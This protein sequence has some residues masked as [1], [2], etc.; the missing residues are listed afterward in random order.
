MFLSGQL[1][2]G[3]RCSVHLLKPAAELTPDAAKNYQRLHA[4]K[5]R[6]GLLTEFDSTRPAWPAPV[7][8]ARAAGGAIRSVWSSI[9]YSSI[10]GV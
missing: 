7:R 6:V 5:A 9:S 8:L 2:P 4:V 3:W 10:K 1:R